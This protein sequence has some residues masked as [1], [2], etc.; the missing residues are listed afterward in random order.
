MMRTM[1]ERRN[2][3]VFAVHGVGSHVPGAMPQSLA[4]QLL[5]TLPKI[6]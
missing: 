2:A 4:N 3:V 1:G 5:E 6:L